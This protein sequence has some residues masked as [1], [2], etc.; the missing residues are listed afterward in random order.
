[1]ASLNKKWVWFVILTIAFF[2]IVISS[3]IAERSDRQLREDLSLHIQIIADSIDQHDIRALSFN[4]GDR[5]NPAFVRVEDWMKKIA[6]VAGCRSLYSMIIRGNGI[7]FGPENLQEKDQY[8]S[9]PGTLYKTPPEKLRSVFQNRK[10]ITVG[11]YT[12]E[13]GTFVSAFA[14]VISPGTGEVVLV[15]GMDIEAADWKW[16]VASD[17]ALPITLTIFLV[18]LMMVFVRLQNIHILLNPSSAACCGKPEK[19][20]IVLCETSTIST[21]VL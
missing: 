7:V 18:L 8:A 11:P 21:A 14:P 17:A 2:G 1:M 10:A 12:D 3:W 9:P 15:I 13:Y 20:G 6:H 5:T 16:N 4:L 19:S